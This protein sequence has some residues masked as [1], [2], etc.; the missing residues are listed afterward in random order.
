MTSLR[1]LRRSGVT[2]GICA[3]LVLGALG[4]SASATD[5]AVTPAVDCCTFTASAFQVDAGTVA[6]LQNDTPTT[7]DVTASQKGPDG[8]PL[9]SSKQVSSQSVPIDGTQYLA[10]GNYPFICTIHAGMSSSFNILPGAQPQARPSADVQVLSQKLSKVASSGKLSV[11][12][13][14]IVGAKGIVL[15]AKK[16]GTTIGTMRN[17]NVSTGQ[18]KTLKVTITASGRKL[19]K[20]VDSAAI[21]VQAA[22][23]FGKAD[24]ASRKLKG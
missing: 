15:I 23:P 18:K 24:K 10:P 20:K 4:A 1:S 19:L 17:I 16:G 9:F 3:G 13:K 6:T 2:V 8:K 5:Q 7:H 21:S 11:T 22:V 12:V 14:G